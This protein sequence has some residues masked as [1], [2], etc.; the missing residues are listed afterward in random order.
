MKKFIK[1]RGFDHRDTFGIFSKKGYLSK[2]ADGSCTRVQRIDEEGNFIIGSRT[3]EYPKKPPPPKSKKRVVWNEF[4]DFLE[5]RKEGLKALPLHWVVFGELVGARNKHRLP[6]PFP[7][8]FQV[9]DVWDDEAARFLRFDEWEPTIEKTG[10]TIIEHDYMNCSYDIINNLMKSLIPREHLFE[11]YVFKTYHESFY[12]GILYG[13]AVHED[14]H[15]IKSARFPKTNGPNMY[16]EERKLLDQ[17]ILRGRVQNVMHAGLDAGKEDVGMGM[18]QWL[19]RAVWEDALAEELVTYVLQKRR[20]FLHLNLDW[21][22]SKA[23]K[24][25]ARQL[26]LIL[27]ERAK[28]AHE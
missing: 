21:M 22:R 13:K 6:Y 1:I 10:L 27:S 26:Q 17:W 25:V 14:V 4:W 16:K 3:V 18:M 15:K 19:S 12:D 8:D 28:E 9:F 5:E 24:L 2:K 20:K 11:G 7:L 23:N